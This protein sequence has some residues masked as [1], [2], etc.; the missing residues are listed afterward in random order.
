MRV[1]G[2]SELL[3]EVALEVAE[4][5]LVSELGLAREQRLGQCQ[6]LIVALRELVLD[7]RDAR[8]VRR[9]GEQHQRTQYE[10]R[11]RHLGLMR[12]RSR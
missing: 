9:C 12:G 4:P 7:D 5:E 3:E 11:R 8:I 6:G 1:L 10:R 2:A